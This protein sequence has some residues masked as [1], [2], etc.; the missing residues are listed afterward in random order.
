VNAIPDPPEWAAGAVD[1]YLERLA[2]QRRLSPSTV[3]AYRR[4]LS[5]F[6]SYCDE[7]GI[8]RLEAVDRATMRG[9]L[10]RLDQAGYA[11]TSAARKASA[12]RSFFRDACRRGIVATNPAD[13]VGISRSSRRLPQPLSARALAT[14][15]DGFEA[16][17]P[18]GLRD[19]AI[20]ELLYAGGL[21]VSELTA[22]RCADLRDRDL[23]RVTGKGGKV[24]VV[25]V[26]RPARAAVDRWLRDGRPHLASPDAG[27]ALF[28]G[29]TGRPLGVRGARRV[30]RARL[31]TF[32][33]ALRHSFATHLLEGGA[34][35][36]TVQELLGHG[37]VATTQ[38]YTHVTRQHLRSAYEQSHPRA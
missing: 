13:G 8:G 28:V 34:D 10:A 36:R 12:V 32:P 17:G 3:D 14:A 1:G 23:L 5:Q 22:V 6:L 31:G 20:L 18:L 27:D 24:R 37:D 19:R 33:H 29:S 2:V 15:L 30:V 21:R 9:Y 4:D 25:P 38:I 11:R 35:L 7:S 16:E 26:G